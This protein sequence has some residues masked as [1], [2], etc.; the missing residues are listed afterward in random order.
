MG[1]GLGR[2]GDVGGDDA[3]VGVATHG[4]DTAPLPL[5]F[6]EIHQLKIVV[7]SKGPFYVITVEFG[8]VGDVVGD[9]M[10]VMYFAPLG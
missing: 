1:L 10:M 3:Y 9:V 7:I 5:G 4:D 8:G 2:V 6:E